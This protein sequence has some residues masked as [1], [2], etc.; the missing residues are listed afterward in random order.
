MENDHRWAVPSG[1]V[2][3]LA[4]GRVDEP[5][6]GLRHLDLPSAAMIAEDLSSVYR[7]RA[8]LRVEVSP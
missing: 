8:I 3:D 4:M 6:L 7:T 1:A 5:P 2:M